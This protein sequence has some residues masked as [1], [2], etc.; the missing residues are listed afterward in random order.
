MAA[1]LSLLAR[2]L[3]NLLTRNLV[4]LSTC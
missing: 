1:P 3:G 2:D 4:G